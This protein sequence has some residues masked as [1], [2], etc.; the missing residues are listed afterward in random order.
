MCGREGLTWDE[1]SIRFHIKGWLKLN[2]CHNI[3]ARD[4]ALKMYHYKAGQML[5]KDLMTDL[6]MSARRGDEDQEIEANAKG[7]TKFHETFKKYNIP[8]SI[9]ILCAIPQIIQ[10]TSGGNQL[11]SVNR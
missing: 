2:V 3:E 6:H 9:P 4:A 11:R 10:D 1:H 5:S 8:I 7:G